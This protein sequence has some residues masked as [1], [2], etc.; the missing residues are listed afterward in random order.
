MLRKLNLRG[1]FNLLIVLPLLTLL[2]VGGMA[3]WNTTASDRALNTLHQHSERQLPLERL[4]RLIGA[5][6]N[7]LVQQIAHVMYRIQQ[8]LAE[9]G[10]R[11]I[12][13]MITNPG[14]IE[15][16]LMQP[17]GGDVQPSRVDLLTGSELT[18]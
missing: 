14:S 5:T 11:R 8:P 9:L 12:K 6:L 1:R 15:I 16:Y 10:G 3:W 2:V 13:Q 17:D 4:E 18:S 7:T